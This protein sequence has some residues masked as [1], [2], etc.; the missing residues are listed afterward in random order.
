M[1]ILAL[2]TSYRCADLVKKM[3]SCVVCREHY[4]KLKEDKCTYHTL[5]PRSWTVYGGKLVATLQF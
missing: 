5:F 2:L 4:W 1:C 3:C